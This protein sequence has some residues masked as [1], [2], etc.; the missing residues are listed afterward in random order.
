[1]GAQIDACRRFEDCDSLGL[2]GGFAGGL[3]GNGD[4][5]VAFVVFGDDPVEVGFDG[6]GRVMVP[7]LI[8]AASCVTDHSHSGPSGEMPALTE[9]YDKTVWSQW[10]PFVC[11]TG[12]QSH[13]TTQHSPLP[14]SQVGT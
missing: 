11:R 7:V 9:W 8:S 4:V 10:K 2:V 12:T 5:G 3:L 14:S 1:M 13:W 6:L